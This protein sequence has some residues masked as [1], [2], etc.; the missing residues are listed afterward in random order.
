MLIPLSFSILLRGAIEKP[1]LGN[2]SMRKC[3][4]KKWKPLKKMFFFKGVSAISVR[5]TEIPQNPVFEGFPL[6]F[7]AFPWQYFP[8][9]GIILSPPWQYFPGGDYY[10]SLPWQYFEGGGE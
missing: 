5:K 1:Q 3:L 9:G 8:G 6:Y 2:V 10:Y 4:Q 7:E